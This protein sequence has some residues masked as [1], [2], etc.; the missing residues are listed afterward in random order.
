M[1]N[2]YSTAPE[3]RR[4]GSPRGRFMTRPTSIVFAILSLLVFTTCLIARGTER[5]VQISEFGKT[6]DGATVYRY[7]LAN[8]KGVEAVVISYGA[9]LNSLKIPDRDG[10]VADV[11]L[12]YGDI[13]GYEQDKA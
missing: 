11:V 3:S 7:V 10:K 8:K 5:K 13:G 9:A 4:F 6:K 2:V 1:V 12:A